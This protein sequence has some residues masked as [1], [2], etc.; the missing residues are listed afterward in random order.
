MID[1]KCVGAFKPLVD[2]AGVYAATKGDLRCSAFRLVDGSL[3]LF[4][5]VLGLGGDALQSLKSIGNVSHLIAPNHYHNAGLVEYAKAFHAARLCAAPEAAP[6]LAKLTG[7][8][9]EDLEALI[10]L[11]PKSFSILEPKG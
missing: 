2:I 8:N 10:K 5:P 11:L 4:S 9:F 7:L 1:S 6:R 3:C